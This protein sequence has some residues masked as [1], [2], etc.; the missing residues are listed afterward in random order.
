[1]YLY[2]PSRTEKGPMTRYDLNLTG[3]PCIV[4]SPEWAG[5][6]LYITSKIYA[7]SSYMSQLHSAPS[8]L[9]MMVIW[10]E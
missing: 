8:P 3:M 9:N 10:N 4:G 5:G 7:S 6:M 2:V 1:M